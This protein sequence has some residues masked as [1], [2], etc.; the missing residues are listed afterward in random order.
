ML[1]LLIVCIMALL[2]LA[3]QQG[4]KGDACYEGHE[5]VLGDDVIPIA[6]HLLPQ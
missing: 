1:P 6:V 4:R 2:P 5:L 3:L